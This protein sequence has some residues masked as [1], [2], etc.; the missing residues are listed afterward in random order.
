M[1]FRSVWTMT[2]LLAALV[3]LAVLIASPVSAK[4]SQQGDSVLK[5]GWGQ[6]FAS[7]LRRRF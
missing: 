3:A 6:R 7:F 1:K 2:G 4:D 5:I